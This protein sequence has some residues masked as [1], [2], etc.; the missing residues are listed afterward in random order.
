MDGETKGFYSLVLAEASS[1][2]APSI[3]VFKPSGSD[4]NECLL[5]VGYRTGSTHSYFTGISD[6]YRYYNLYAVEKFAEPFS[7][8]VVIF[9]FHLGY[10]HAARR[11]HCACLLPR[12][13]HQSPLCEQGCVPIRVF[14]CAYIHACVRLPGLV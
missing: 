14:A 10:V 1:R 5:L 4:A 3:R 8:G 6:V 2:M 13:E 11:T 9:G 12:F 7:N